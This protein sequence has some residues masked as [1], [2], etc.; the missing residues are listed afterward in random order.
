MAVHTLIE[1]ARTRVLESQVKKPLSGLGPCNFSPASVHTAVHAGRTPQ[2]VQ[3]YKLQSLENASSEI[4]DREH[5]HMASLEAALPQKLP[6]GRLE[7]G[8]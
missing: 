7:S 3:A 1:I 4:E 2:L 6:E 5:L 8:K